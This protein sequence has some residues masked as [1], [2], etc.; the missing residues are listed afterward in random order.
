MEHSPAADYVL[1]AV[2][3][4]CL[5]FGLIGELYLMI[6]IRFSKQIVFEYILKV[7]DLIFPL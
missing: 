6:L 2:C 5:V 7:Y 1:S 3:I 4:F